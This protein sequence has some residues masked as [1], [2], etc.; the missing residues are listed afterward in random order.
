MYKLF[1]IPSKIIKF[2]AVGRGESKP[3]RPGTPFRW[4][5]RCRH[6]V[7]VRVSSTL[8]CRLFVFVQFKFFAMSLLTKHSAEEW[9]YLR[10][11]WNTVRRKGLRWITM[12][13]LFLWRWEW[14]IVTYDLSHTTSEA[15]FRLRED[16]LLFACKQ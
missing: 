1:L 12:R 15:V 2:W 14:T 7:P 5:N 16:S 10:N 4:K 11:M 9:V 13:I 6:G 3:E 8:I